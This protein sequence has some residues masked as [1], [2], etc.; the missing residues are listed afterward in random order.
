M[1]RKCIY[2]YTRKQFDQLDSSDI[3]DIFVAQVILDW[4]WAVS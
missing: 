3:A 2:I 1:S 4:G